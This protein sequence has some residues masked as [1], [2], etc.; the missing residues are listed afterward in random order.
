MPDIP[1]TSALLDN[2][3][4]MRDFSGERFARPKTAVSQVVPEIQDFET[5]IMHWT[6]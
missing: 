1:I 2:I 4:L 5:E 3:Q 6:E